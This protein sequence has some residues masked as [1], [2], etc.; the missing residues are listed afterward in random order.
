MNEE[1]THN[2]ELN[3]TLLKYAEVE[4]NPKLINDIIIK[5]ADINSAN[6][7]GCNALHI[8]THQHNNTIVDILIELKASLNNID[9]EGNTALHY[10][11]LTKNRIAAVAL[12]AVGA[13]PNIKNHDN[14]TA[15][16]IAQDK[17][18]YSMI[19]ALL[20]TATHKFKSFKKKNFYKNQSSN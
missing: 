20:P 4:D 8:A 1:K 15:L 18:N 9:N 3:N 10:A 12:I 2:S 13:N 7:N 5:G 16:K 17:H 14:K 6:S 19:K 11:V